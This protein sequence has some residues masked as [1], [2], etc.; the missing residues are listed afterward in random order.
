MHSILLPCRCHLGPDPSWTSR[1]VPPLRDPVSQPFGLH[2]RTI[3]QRRVRGVFT[4]RVRPAV[5]VGLV[6][7]LLS[8]ACP[9]ATTLQPK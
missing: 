7:W 8:S 2:A 4:D 1:I 3:P 5:L 9:T 6:V